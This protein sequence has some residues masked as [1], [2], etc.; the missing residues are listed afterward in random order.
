MK[1]WFIDILWDGT[2]IRCYAAKSDPDKLPEKIEQDQNGVFG[3]V[4]ARTRKEAADIMTQKMQEIKKENISCLT[5]I[6]K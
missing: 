2:F 4:I 1:A 5:N 6:S 3:V